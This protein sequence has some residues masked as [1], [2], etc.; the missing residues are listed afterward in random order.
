M[1]IRYISIENIP[2]KHFVSENARGAVLALHGFGGS[3][4]SAAIQL[5]A[6]RLCPKG[7]DIIAPDWEAHGERGKDFSRLSVSGC[8]SDL[9]RVEK[10]V[11]GN[12]SENI[13]VF[14]TS[15]GG[16][17]T[18]LRMEENAPYKR[19]V[20]RVPA[21]NMADSLVNAARLSNPDITAETARALGYFPMRMAEEFRVPFPLYEE[22]AAKSCVRK[23]A[24]W[25]GDRIFTVYAEN[26]ELVRRRDTEEFIKLND[27]PAKMISGTGHRMMQPEKLCEALDA[28]ADKL[29]EII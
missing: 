3:K 23:C 17:I 27:I 2:A 16:F 18:L 12:I 22:L 14:A 19:V 5:L 4:E 24:A 25:R 20:L 28:A 1:T 29:T 11:G 26:D 13:G 21:V 15:F 9:R 10:F 8:I 7:I 6:E